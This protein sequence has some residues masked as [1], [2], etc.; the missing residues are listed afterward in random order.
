MTDTSESSRADCDPHVVILGAG[1]A[2]YGVAREFRKHDKQTPLTL[3]T[4][5]DGAVYYK[6]D[7]S[8]AYAVG[9]SPDDLVQRSAETMAAELDIEIRAHHQVEAIEPADK[10]LQLDGETLT[11]SRLVLAMGAEPIRLNLAGDG[12]EAVHKINNLADYQI[13]RDDLPAGGRVVILGA[14]LI[15][16]EFANDLV[17]A[18]HDVSVV[19]PV[20]WPLAQFLPKEAGHAVQDAL[21]GAGVDYR[22]GRTGSGVHHGDGD[23]LEV[24]LDDN[25]VIRADFVLS[26]VG[27]NPVSQLAIDAGLEVDRGVVVDRTLA[28]SDPHIYALGDCAEV[29]GHWRPY[30]APLMQCARTLGKTLAAGSDEPAGQVK[31]PA[32]PII[33]KTHKCPVVVYPPLHRPGEWQINAADGASVEAEFVDTNGDCVGFALTG[34]ATNKR[35]DYLKRVPPILA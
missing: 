6:P 34:E 25:S 16:S 3:I 18:G 24:W 9:K 11:Y 10:R 20:E 26:A 29:A 17:T 32:L 13:F 12:V 30:V 2:A 21:A 4:R 15:G 5:D 22:L 28:T 33:I 27:L 7:I 35:R 31:Y 1:L 8:E 23:T 14:G 19:D